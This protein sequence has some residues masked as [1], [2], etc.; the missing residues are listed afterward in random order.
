MNGKLMH[1]RHFYAL[2]VGYM[3]LHVK[4]YSS[5]L[6]AMPDSYISLI[7]STLLC[8]IW[9]WKEGRNEVN[10]SDTRTLASESWNLDHVSSFLP[11]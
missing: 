7:R 10:F 6:F 4:I 11:I 9:D 3:D 2:N 1:T 5:S 8:S